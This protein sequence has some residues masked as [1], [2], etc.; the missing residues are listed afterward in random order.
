M[1]NS[2]GMTP[3]I[4]EVAGSISDWPKYMVSF[5]SKRNTVS[6]MVFQFGKKFKEEPKC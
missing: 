1:G 3:S 6:E 4:W 5:A 2:R